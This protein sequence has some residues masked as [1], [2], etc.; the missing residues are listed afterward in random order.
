[1]SWLIFAFMGPVLWAV[2]THF[3]KYLVERYFKESSVA[4]L[5]VFTALIGL[6]MMPFIWAYYPDVLIMPLRAIALIAL[7]GI[8][9]MAAMYFYLGALQGEEASVVAPFYQASPLFGYGLAYIIL[10]ETLRPLQMAGGLLIVAGAT[11]VSIRSGTHAGRFKARLVVRMLSCA[12][13]LAVATVIFKAFAIEDEFWPTTF[14]TYVGEAVFG[15]VL[16]L[17]P[18]Y[19]REFFALFKSNTWALLGI[20]GSNE[21]INLG[22]GLGSRYALMFAPLSLV[23]AVNSTTTLFVFLIG[24][25]ITLLAPSLGR[26]DLSARNLLRKGLSAILVVIGLIAMTQG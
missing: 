17:I 15:I 11:M 21:L 12:F 9:Y 10:G 25:G 18:T 24:I 16:L 23:Q 3:D 5:L 26:E 19:R 20:N 14:W 22:G 1:M 6:V 7:S 2:S 4:S 13:A 8:L